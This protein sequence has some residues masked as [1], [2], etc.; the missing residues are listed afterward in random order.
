MRT[1]AD[2]NADPHHFVPGPRIADAQRERMAALL[3]ATSYLEYC[4][5]GN[6]LRLPLVA[7]QR[8]QNIDPYIAHA[9]GL[10]DGAGRFKGFYT[11]ATIAEFADVH[12]VSYYRDEMRAMDAAYDAFIALHARAS[13]LFVAS[14]AIEER[15]RGSGLLNLMLAHIAAL[16]RAKGSPR[17]VLTVW[18]NSAAMGIYLNKGFVS[19]AV[20][21]YAAELFFDRLHFM[22]LV[23]PGGSQ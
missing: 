16:A 20:F 13:D 21:D 19:L 1:K 22:E 3:F 4:S 6:R 2:V 23:P 8:R 15:F 7:L 11:A 10:Y 18:E 9:H 5:F 12:A 17:T 14:L